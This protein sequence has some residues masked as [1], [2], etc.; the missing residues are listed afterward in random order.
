MPPLTRKLLI[1]L[2]ILIPSAQFAWRNR[3][4]PQLAYMHDDG[5]FFVSAKALAA[6]E[7]F[8]IPS[9]PETPAQTKYPILY[10]AYLSLI[11]L[12]NPAFPANLPLATLASWLALVACLA[13]AYAYYRAAGLPEPRAWILV[14]LL[15]S[16]PYV[17]LFG[18]TMFSEIF[19]TGFVLASMIAARRP[20]VRAALLAGALAGGA[21][22]ARTA[23]LALFLA[24]P[25]WMLW[26]RETRR[27]AY[28][29]AAMLPCI[30]GWMLW[31]RAHAFPSP[32]ETLVYYTDYVRYQFLNVGWDNLALVVWNNADQILYGLGSLVLPKVFES[33]PVK[34]LT[35]V[36]A[37][38]MI[39]GVVRLVR[40]GQFLE[41]AA[42][43]V[44]SCLMLLP[45]H[46]PPTERFVL[47]LFPLALA[48]LLTELERLAGMIR[49]ALRHRDASQRAAARVFGFG[50][51]A[52]FTGAFALQALMTFFLLHETAA[53]KRARRESLQPAYAWLAANVPAGAGVLSYDD[54]LTYLHAGRRGNYLPIRPRWW[55]VK[56]H[57]QIVAT[58]DGLAEYCRA[59]GLAYVLH[60]PGD[61]ERETGEAD[62]AAIAKRIETAPGL[63]FLRR[64]GAASLYAVEP[65]A[66]EN[67]RR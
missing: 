61:L 45:W 25:A 52:L 9:L 38:A 13:L 59:R 5:V 20:G 47:P 17:V 34:I 50:V 31:T 10:P 23:G 3:D 32:D 54:T 8:R 60:A 49:G 48:G 44:A 41:Y 63:R 42:F 39:A 37:I 16:S 58:Y 22:L 33:L 2:A 27:A 28:F 67:A 62:R 64:A 43:A 35:E 66:V 12:L 24:L 55:Y 40:R 29:A 57:E 7:G 15:G 18:T 46:Y 6:G 51:A 30:L 53:E 14:A 1:F 26:R 65:P 4:M 11:W 21:Y 36:I 19:F 56:D